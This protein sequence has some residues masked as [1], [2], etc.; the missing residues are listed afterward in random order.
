MAGFAERAEIVWVVGLHEPF[1]FVVATP[2]VCPTFVFAGGLDFGG[3]ESRFVFG[4]LPSFRRDAVL[5]GW[6][7]C[8][9]RRD[10]DLAG[11]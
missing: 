2:R 11:T 1:F 10:T 7:C 9:V 6:V 4:G 8:S 3:C 5:A